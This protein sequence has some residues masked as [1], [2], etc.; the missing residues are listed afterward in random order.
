MEPL[1][2]YRLVKRLG[3]GGFGQVWEAIGPGEVRV[4]LKFV[5]LAD[6]A[7]ALEQQALQIIKNIRHPNLLFIFGIWPTEGWLIIGMELA[8]ET[9]LD[10]HHAAVRHNA[11]GL[12]RPELLRYAREAAKVIDFLNKPRHF[13]GGPRPV[14]IAHGDVKPQNILLVSGGVK[15]GDF[16]LVRLLEKTASQRPGGM[17]PAYAAPEVFNGQPS[18]WSDQYSLAMTYC[19]L[20]GG[21]LPIRNN[22]AS[23]LTMLPEA[24]RPAVARALA[25]NPRERWPNCREFIRALTSPAA[26][27]APP[28]DG[29]AQ[30][31]LERRLGMGS[32]GE[33]WEATGSTG[34]RL[35]VKIFHHRLNPDGNSKEL[36]PLER[37]RH[38]SHP[39]LLSVYGYRVTSEHNLHLLLERADSSLRDRLQV[40]QGS[41]RTGI[42]RHELLP[43]L[44]QTALAL[45]Y[46]HGQH[47]LHRDIR[48]ENILLKDGEAKV[49]E[50]AFPHLQEPQGHEALV[51]TSPAYWAPEVFRGRG[52]EPSDQYGLAITY[53]ELRTGRRPFPDRA[54]LYES[55]LDTLEGAPDL[56]ALDDREREVVQRSL[57]KKPEDRFPN[58]L[59]WMEALEAACGAEMEQ[60]ARKT[61]QLADETPVQHE[62]ERLTQ[63]GQPTPSC[64][65]E[66]VVDEM[67][68]AAANIGPTLP[69]GPER[70]PGLLTQPRARQL[71]GTRARLYLPWLLGACALLLAGL[72]ALLVIQF[73][74]ASETE[75]L[76]PGS[77][78]MAEQFALAKKSELEDS[79]E[80]APA[81]QRA[82]I[83]GDTRL[84]S[85][86]KKETAIPPSQEAKPG[87]KQ[88]QEPPKKQ[89]HPPAV[90]P[91]APRS[92]GPPRAKGSSTPR[93]A[94]RPSPATKTEP[95][96]GKERPLPP[97]KETSPTRDKKQEPT[98]PTSPAM[99]EKKD[100][101]APIA[102]VEAQATPGGQVVPGGS[103]APAYNVPDSP[104]EWSWAWSLIGGIGS[105]VLV[106]LA[107]AL[108]VRNRRKAAARMT[109]E[110]GTP[111]EVEP[112][113]VGPETDFQAAQFELPLSD[114]PRLSECFQGHTDS[115]WGLAFSAEGHALL[116]GGMDNTVRLWDA[117]GE[118]LRLGGHADG[119]TS[120]ALAPDRM[121]AISGSLDGSVLL[122]DL[123]RGMFVRSL[124]SAGGRVL[125]VAW[126][127]DS[128][129]AIWGGEDRT[130]YLA[131]PDEAPRIR[132]L[133]G[134][135]NWITSLTISRD[136]QRIASGSEDGTVRL[137]DVGSGHELGRFNG[138]D[139][140]VRCVAIAPDGQSILSGGNDAT[141]RLLDATSLNEVRRFAGHTDWVHGVAFSP[142]G[143]RV[144]SGSADETVRL[145]RLTTG[146]E[147]ERFEGHTE[148]ILCVACSP[149]GRYIA[150]GSDDTTIRLW[151][152]SS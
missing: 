26:D 136:G 40:C 98:E 7:G 58:C 13:L 77:P 140:A 73:R 87:P 46:L 131:N 109:I 38:L 139:G 101:E 106:V 60:A 110:T 127:A 3:E 123:R 152:L 6:Q 96:D 11:S 126:S 128:R 53:V 63:C 19:F 56:S 89:P 115:V 78:G 31:H 105:I 34:I 137:W 15:L 43:L 84:A 113:V 44:K 104:S 122:W 14:G 120:V 151:P 52:C 95:K 124:Q 91:P 61:E 92:G 16:G 67:Q 76:A 142:D 54:S 82:E 28:H 39:S 30:Y 20:R 74:A 1:A 65:A 75:K 108:L 9:L 107:L 97:G 149:N 69:L 37:L 121:R 99:L 32:M 147:L 102:P 141:I 57:A 10:R 129:L 100:V 132:V 83:P 134:H 114:A 117:K 146:E 8:D 33:V 79:M 18:R 64:G 47:I 103:T 66:H 138:H 81:P 148:S 24:E 5:P 17:T 29:E 93:S 90:R 45:D 51:A 2:G 71:D 62:K 50:V 86:Q 27:I 145:W 112:S 59:A 125:A 21:K 94:K 68:H 116:S 4:A 41:G 36:E 49:S 42:P 130:I 70:Q 72:C 25:R 85:P 48:P 133:N 119:I 22:S 23:E 88:E 55:M 150:S 144:V 35:V 143:T 111:M 12:S 118:K 135:D 80:L